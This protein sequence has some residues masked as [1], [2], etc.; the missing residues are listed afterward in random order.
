MHVR[1]GGISFSENPKN[2]RFLLLLLGRPFLF[3]LLVSLSL[4]FSAGLCR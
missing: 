4:S 3:K 2:L 1:T